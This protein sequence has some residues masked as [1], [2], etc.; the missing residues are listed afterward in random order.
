M[1]RDAILLLMVVVALTLIGLLALYSATALKPG[2]MGLLERQLLCL[3]AGVV[4]MFYVAKHFDYH[5][6]NTPWVFRGLVLAAVALLALVFIPG[7]GDEANG[8]QR[9]VRIAGFRFQPSELA[10]VALIILLARKLTENREF[11]TEFR[12]GLAPP[13]IIAVSFA[14]LVYMERDMGVPVVMMS[15]AVAMLL[16]AGMPFRY[17]AGAG[18]L[19]GLAVTAMI[20]EQPYRLKRVTAFLDPYEAR[21]E[22]GFNLIQSLSGFAR[23]HFWGVGPGAGE[24]KLAYLPAAHTDFIFAIVGEEAGLAGTALVVVLFAALLML[25]LRIARRAPDL[26]GCLLATG[27][28]V[29][30]ALQTVINIASATGLMPTKGLPLPFMSYGGTAQ[31]AFLAMAGI[32]MSI[33]LQAVEPVEQA[34]I[35]P[36]PLGVHAA[37]R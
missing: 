32:L 20:L 10:K 4:A 6:F 7:F 25:G 2:G 22:G 28:T 37:A 23:G 31:I 27:I 35:T 29:L 30:I 33:A 34:E 13:L 21:D 3:G 24:Q 19:G 14:G 8:A 26:F 15:V 17:V 16:V 36:A 9:W 11:I 1:R 18:A 5:R 12:R